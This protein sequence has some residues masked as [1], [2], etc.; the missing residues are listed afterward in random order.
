M[1][2]LFAPASW[3]SEYRA[4]ANQG[5]NFAWG[6]GRGRTLGGGKP[7]RGWTGRGTLCVTVIHGGRGDRG[8]LVT[9]HKGVDG[10]LC[11]A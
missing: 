7:R 2:I 8:V 1:T 9:G 6:L 5:Y 10:G 3:Q 11:V 4:A